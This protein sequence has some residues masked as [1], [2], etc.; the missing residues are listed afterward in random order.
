M[1]GDAEE[2]ANER[3]SHRLAVVLRE[4]NA[5]DAFFN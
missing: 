1:V 5:T 4:M 2:K 3:R